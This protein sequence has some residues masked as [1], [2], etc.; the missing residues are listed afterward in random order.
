MTKKFHIVSNNEMDGGYLPVKEFYY[1]PNGN[2][3]LLPP[4]YRDAINASN[5]LLP[6]FLNPY[7]LNK[8]ARYPNYGI[9]YTVPFYINSAGRQS[10]I[11][12]P[13][14]LVGR[15]VDDIYKIKADDVMRNPTS[16]QN[17]VFNIKIP[18]TGMNH[19]I[20]LSSDAH[21]RVLEYIRDNY[22]SIDQNRMMF[23]NANKPGCLLDL[24]N[25]CV[26]KTSNVSSQPIPW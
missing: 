13:Y 26:G 15:M 22:N 19:D 11:V 16:V 20:K 6:P 4:M 23:Y 17:V 10:K 7:S 5:T 12:I 25:Q 21:R 14:N 3:S 18:N 24:L 8:Y 2:T 9:P 1:I